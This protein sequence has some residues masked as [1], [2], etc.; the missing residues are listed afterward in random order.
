MLI[1]WTRTSSKEQMIMLLPDRSVFSYLAYAPPGDD[2]DIELALS[3]DLASVRQIFRSP[4]KQT[5]MRSLIVDAAF[6]RDE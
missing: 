4:C 1:S 3:K 6:G 2:Q 5:Y